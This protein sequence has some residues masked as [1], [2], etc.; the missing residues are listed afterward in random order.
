MFK[1]TPF[2]SSPRKRDEFVDFYNLVDD[3][4]SS[5]FR[6]IRGDSFKLDVK[7]EEKHYLIE[8]DVPGIKRE[9]IK[10]SY[11]DDVLTIAIERDEEKEEKTENYLHRERQVCSMKRSLNLPGV[12]PQKVKAKLEEGVLKVIAEKSEVQEHSYVIEVE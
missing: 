3:F 11:N 1:L 2:S 12:D 10:I 5:P 9:E 4:F 7:E 6:S 8:A